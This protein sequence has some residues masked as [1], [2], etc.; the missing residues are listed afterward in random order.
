[1]VQ[2]RSIKLFTASTEHLTTHLHVG[3]VNFLNKLYSLGTITLT[4]WTS[5]RILTYESPKKL[6]YSKAYG[7]QN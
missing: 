5:F 3:L 6:V 7:I 1:M 4:S 2:E